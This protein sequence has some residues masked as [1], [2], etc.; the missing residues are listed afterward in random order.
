M[1]NIKYLPSFYYRSEEVKNI[2]VSL[3]SEDLEIKQAIDD[4]LNQLFVDTATWGLDRW[5]EMLNLKVDKNESYE[6]RRARIKTRIRGIGTFNKAMIKNLCKS[7]VNGDVCII[8]NNSNSSFVIKFIDIKGIP[9]N[10]EYLKDAVEEVKPAHLN[11]S[12]EYLYNTWGFLKSKIW[13][14]LTTKTWE[15]LKTI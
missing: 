10:L 4:M 1:D 7:F 8:E 9:G 11:F 3:Q 5:E 2:Q 12:F 13:E 14:G 6:N 15:E